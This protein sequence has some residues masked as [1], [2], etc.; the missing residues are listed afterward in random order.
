MIDHAVKL[1]RESPR[2]DLQAASRW[3]LVRWGEQSTVDEIDASRTRS[4][5]PAEGHEWFTNGQGLTMVVIPPGEF[6]MGSLSSEPER[7]PYEDRHQVAITRRF[8]I[9]DREITR[10]QFERFHL[11]AFGQPYKINIEQYSP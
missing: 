9:A 11:E 8:A 1:Y 6:W 2:R 4:Q 5:G 7:F 10:E 3:L